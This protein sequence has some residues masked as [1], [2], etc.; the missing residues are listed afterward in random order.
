M[1]F[2]F[3]LFPLDALTKEAIEQFKQH[4]IERFPEECCGLVVSGEYIP[5]TNLSKNPR[6]SFKIDSRDII[7]A[8]E[9][10]NA[11]CHSHPNQTHAQLSQADITASE[12]F[13]VQWIVLSIFPSF[14]ANFSQTN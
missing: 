13:T 3:D 2:E 7:R 9:R 14:D 10:L 12:N 5:C 8:G 1:N 4:A 11:V 6:T